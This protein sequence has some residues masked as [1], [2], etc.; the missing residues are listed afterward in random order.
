[1][2]KLEILTFDIE[3][4]LWHPST[5]TLPRPAAVAVSILQ[6][7]YANVRDAL[8]SELTLRAMGL[9]YVTILSIVPLL[10]ISF[11]ILKAFNFHREVEPLLANLLLPLGGR[12]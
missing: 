12:G 5:E 4:A 9:V 2:S 8:T 11:S 3:S 6:F 1:M 10:A 7:I